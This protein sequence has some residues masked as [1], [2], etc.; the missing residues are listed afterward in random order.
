MG[1]LEDLRDVCVECAEQREDFSPADD[2]LA[3]WVDAGCPPYEPAPW[4]K[5]GEVPT[6]DGVYALEHEG[7]GIP[8]VVTL[9]GGRCRGEG[10]GGVFE[11]VN[12]D[13]ARFRYLCPLPTPPEE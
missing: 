2:D 5:A 12:T 11:L 6:E 4:G 10:F 7:N 9:R 13:D 3:A 1:T 8:F